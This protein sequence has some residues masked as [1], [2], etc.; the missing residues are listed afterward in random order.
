V[1]SNYTITYA[2]G[3]LTVNPAALTIT[4]SSAT[5]TYGA[6]DPTFGASY[7]G[8]VNG[9]TAGSLTTG[10]SIA[11]AGCA[12]T[13]TTAGSHT[14]TASG[15]VDSNYTIIY[16]TGTLSVAQAALA[17]M[18]NDASKTYGAADPTFGVSY[19]GFVNG[20]T[21]SSLTTVP[22]V[23]C[24]GCA[25]TATTAGSHTLTA[26]GAV[27]SNYA[28]TYTQGTLTVNAANGGGGNGNGGGN[29]TNNNSSN[30]L[31]SLPQTVLHTLEDSGGDIGYTIPTSQYLLSPSSLT[32]EYGFPD[33]LWR[34]T[35]SYRV[36]MGYVSSSAEDS[37]VY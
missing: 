3:T 19:N 16:A 2:T 36:Q 1:D 25:G 29:G 24:A 28:I 27:D 10:P 5:K 6:A 15:A 21:A 17:I 14:L 34:Y 30:V 11:C 33:N 13:A 37:E 35:P 8:F 4:A 9:D 26:S 7:S 23:A 31:S 12:G 20:D 18:A 32:S 22:T